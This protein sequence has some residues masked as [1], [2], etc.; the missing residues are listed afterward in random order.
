MLIP[1]C[2]IAQPTYDMINNITQTI[3]YRKIDASEA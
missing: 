2:Q 3:S 1:H